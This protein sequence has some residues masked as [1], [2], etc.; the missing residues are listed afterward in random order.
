MSA[1]EEIFL[2]KL[3][4]F[5]DLSE[6]DRV[7]MREFVSQ[8]LAVGEGQHLL[9]EGE[10]NQTVF[11]L[12]D[13]WAIRYKLLPDGRRQVI[14]FLLPGDIFG[15]K[16]SLFDLSNDSV[17]ALTDV[18]VHPVP[19]TQIAGLTDGNPNLALALAW[20]RG[21]EHSILTE[22][23][24]RLGRRTAYERVAHLLMEL[25]HRL[26]LVDL[27][28]ARAYPLPLTQE[29]LADTLGLSIVHVNRTMRKLRKDGLISIDT[30]KRMIRIEDLQGLADAGHYD[31]TFLDQDG[32]PSADVRDALSGDS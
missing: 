10:E 27:A 12:Q 21:R 5:I 19:A 20:A 18:V 22:H 7:L 2:T 17:Q 25:L 3:G 9:S 14:S 26:Q 28:S 6:D 15:F 16:E 13:G 23:V 31:E 11:F 24:V 30:D 8:K 29:L 32:E 4:S 1:Y